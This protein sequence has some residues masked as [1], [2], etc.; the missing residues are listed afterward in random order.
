MKIWP[1]AH[2]IERTI[3]VEALD[4]SLITQDKLNRAALQ[5]PQKPALKKKT[6]IEKIVMFP[7]NILI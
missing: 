7:A 4:T 6:P 1:K 5:N 2:P 3:G